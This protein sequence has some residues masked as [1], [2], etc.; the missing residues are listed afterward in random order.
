MTGKSKAAQNAAR[1]YRLAGAQVAFEEYQ[2]I[3]PHLPR[4]SNAVF[5]HRRFTQYEFSS[6]VH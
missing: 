2:F 4:D 5:E 6:S 1:E 3:R